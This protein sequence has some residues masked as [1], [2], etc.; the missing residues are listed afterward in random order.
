MFLD[1]VTLE[2]ALAYDYLLSFWKDDI[3]IAFSL[4]CTEFSHIY[5]T[6]AYDKWDEV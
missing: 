6:F 2:N 1:E 4:S 3:D 5:F